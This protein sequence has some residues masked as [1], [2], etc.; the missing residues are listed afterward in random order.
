V[1]VDKLSISLDP[2][3]GDAVRDSARHRG[4]SVSAWLADAAAAKLRAEALADY[5]DRREAEDGPF[6]AEELT[7][8]ARELGLPVPAPAA[9]TS[10]AA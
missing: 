4:S 8:A 10:R 2:A 3:L 9:P 1:K 5:L 6:T 7:A